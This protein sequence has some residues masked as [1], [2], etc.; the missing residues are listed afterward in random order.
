MQL[1]SGQ[2]HEK[3]IHLKVGARYALKTYT[4]MGKLRVRILLDGFC[5][6]QFSLMAELDL[7]SMTL[8]DNLSLKSEC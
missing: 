8:L 1:N 3:S 2:G 6:F 7:H 5:A 4:M